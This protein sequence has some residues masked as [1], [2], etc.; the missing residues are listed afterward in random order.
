[1]TRKLLF[2]IP[3]A[4]FLGFS[5]FDK[6]GTIS[7]YHNDGIESVMY[8]AN[9]PNAKTGAPGD[10]TCTDCHT[11]TT[12]SAA[13]TIT[14]AFSGTGNEYTPGQ[15]YT[16][17][18]SIAAGAKNGFQLTVLDASD[19][20]AGTFNSGTNSATTSAGGK[21]YVHHSSS[22]GN[23]AWQFTWNAP[24]TDMGPV[25]VYY[26][27][28]ATDNGGSTGNDVV[29]LGQETIT[30]VDNVSIT[31]HDQLDQAYRVIVDQNANQLTLKYAT[32]TSSDVTLNVIDMSGK[33]VYREALGQKSAGNQTDQID[34]SQFN[35]SGIY[36]VSLLIDN[37]AINRKV[38]LK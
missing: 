22:V 32:L 11:G 12:Q 28:N 23:T 8:S 30:V 20:A 9:P 14:Y 10:G 2:L 19:N 13:G 18:L 17:D 26:A 25:T 36:F 29:Y 6:E 33:L 34:I 3:I 4:G 37:D 38:M 16:I 24:S 31:A 15:S 5:Y 7:T 27:F 21:E 35:K 1:M